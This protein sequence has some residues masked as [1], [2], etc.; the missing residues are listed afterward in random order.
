MLFLI[1]FVVLKQPFHHIKQ[2]PKAPLPFHF[3]MAGDLCHGGS[4]D[5]F[6]EVSGG[7]SLSLS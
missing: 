5:Y 2:I 7:K 4:P 1:L 6:L 3:R